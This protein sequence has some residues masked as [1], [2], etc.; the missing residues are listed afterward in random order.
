MT[1]LLTAAGALVIR[2]VFDYEARKKRRAMETAV[3]RL[4]VTVL[5]DERYGPG[6]KQRLDV[7]IPNSALTSD[8]LLPVVLWTHGGAWLSGDKSDTAPYFRMLAARG[9][10]VVG[11]NYSLAPR[12]QFPTPLHELNRAHQFILDNAERFRIDPER[13]I[14]AGDSAGA[15]LSGQLAAAVTD[16]AYA[17]GLELAPALQAEQLRAVVLYC[18]IYDAAALAQGAEAPSS[19]K[20]VSWGLKTALAAYL[21][22]AAPSPKRL[23]QM[24]VL[25]QVGRDFPAAFI[26]GGNGDNLTVPQSRALANRLNELGV[27]VTAVFYPDDHSPALLH[28]HQFVLDESGLA[29]FADLV[30]FLARVSA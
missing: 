16:P 7:Y 21:G 5:R 29:N 13:V 19:S 6:R 23:A 14:L 10:V 15:N 9:Y 11:L 2:A 25:A 12:A 17:Q 24:S 27:P 30:E 4:D 3:P 26:S 22:S 18:G 8:E 28:E 20:I 1:R